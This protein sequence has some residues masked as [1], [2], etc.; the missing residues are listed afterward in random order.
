MIF[1]I[2]NQVDQKQDFSYSE[3]ISLFINNS[4]AYENYRN[5]QPFERSFLNIIPGTPE[6]LTISDEDWR[7]LQQE[8]KKQEQYINL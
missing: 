8:L 4:R 5:G 6:P 2:N 3:L 7:Q 1:Y